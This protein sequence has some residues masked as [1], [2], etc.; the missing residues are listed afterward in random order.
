MK[1]VLTV[2]IIAVLIA[3]VAIFAVIRKKKM[4]AAAKAVGERP[5]P[6][7]VAE[8]RLGN[9]VTS[10]RYVGVIT[11]LTM[12]NISSRITSEV[13]KVHHREGEHVKK[14][15]LLLNLDD[16]NFQ[17]A[18]AVEN[19]KIEN[20][21][22]Q[23]EANN[24]LIKSLQNS[25]EYWKKQ[26]DR[27][28][29]LYKQNIVPAKQL[30]TSREKLNEVTGQ[31]DVALQKRKTLV[32]VLNAA[33]GAKQI[34]KTNITYANIT[35][36]FDCVVCDV[37]IYPGDLASPGKKLMMIEDHKHLKVVIKI[38]QIDM[39]SVKLGDKIAIQSRTNKAVVEITKIYPSVGINKMVRIEAKIPEKYADTFVSGQY[40]LTYLASKVKHNALI[41]PSKAINLDNNNAT[42]NILFLYRN[43]KLKKIT[44][45]VISDNETEAAVEGDLKPG[46]EVVVTAFLG[47]AK[48]AD[49][50]IVSKQ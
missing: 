4:L 21:K 50:M 41:I 8:V 31:Y 43:G 47:W 9:F 26:V 38:P 28:N 14:G 19:A 23:I 32:A 15:E 48:L 39:S 6:V 24:V 13:E 12:A 20:V 1:K 10:K 27:D 42:S 45:K 44:V 18:L 30:E 36:P 3:G 11:P 25:V 37:P 49:G 33:E 46:D 2:I 16:R 5:V 29:E 17:Q 22:T 35:A 7:S 34:A 40:V